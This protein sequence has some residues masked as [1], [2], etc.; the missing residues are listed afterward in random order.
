MLSDFG[1]STQLTDTNRRRTVIGTPYW[2]A[3]EILQ[4]TSCK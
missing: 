1:V 2:M 3:P 4:E